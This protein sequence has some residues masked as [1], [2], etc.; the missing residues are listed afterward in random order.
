MPVLRSP[1]SAVC[2]LTR[3]IAHRVGRYL[4]RM[5]LLE[6]DAGKTYL[7]RP[8]VSANRLSMT[9]N[10][11]VRYELKTPWRNGTTHVISAER[12]LV[13]KKRGD[14]FYGSDICLSRAVL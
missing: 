4:E 1:D 8:A 9:R 7:T 6:C 5:G 11:R 2:G 13:A 10:A 14:T 3:T 12:D